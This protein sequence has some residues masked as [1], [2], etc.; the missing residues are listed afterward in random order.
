MSNYVKLFHKRQMG[1]HWAFSY[2]S[3]V[4]SHSLTTLVEFCHWFCYCLFKLNCFVI[5]S[6]GKWYNL[7][8]NELSAWKECQICGIA[9]MR[10]PKYHSVFE[11]NYPSWF[12]WQCGIRRWFTHSST[13]VGIMFQPLHHTG[14]KGCFFL[15]F[16][17]MA[18][19]LK[20]PKQLR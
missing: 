11:P 18:I 5:F 16:S 3:I 15:W 14:L 4:L 6:S 10:Y 9:E 2:L 20:V 13:G 8:Y 1:W 7:C 12:G 17:H 19:P